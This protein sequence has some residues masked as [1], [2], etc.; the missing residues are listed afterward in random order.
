MVTIGLIAGKASGK[1][2]TFKLIKEFLP[3]ARELMLAEHLKRATSQA[4]AISP[5]SVESQEEKERPFA[6]PIALTLG[7]LIEVARIFE[8]RASEIATPRHVGRVLRTPREALQYIG[9]EVLRAA[10]PDVHLKW[11]MRLAPPSSA[12]VVTDIRF[13]N[14]FDFFYHGARPFLPFYIERG[15]APAPGADGHASE[16]YALALKGRCLSSLDNNGSIES[17][18]RQV[19]EKVVRLAKRRLASP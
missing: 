11:A 5:E 16:A 13:P 9:T 6:R 1:T 2:T 4:L 10:E 7:H 18:R 8:M 14:E 19:E 3:Q 15:Q 12:Y 17:L